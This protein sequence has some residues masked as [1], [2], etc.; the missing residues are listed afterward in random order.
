MNRAVGLSF[1]PIREGKTLLP[2]TSLSVMGEIAGVNMALLGGYLHSTKTRVPETQRPRVQPGEGWAPP[3][4][5]LPKTH[6]VMITYN[7]TI[8]D[9]LPPGSTRTATSAVHQDG[10]VKCATGASSRIHLEDSRKRQ[11][12][13]RHLEHKDT[14]TCRGTCRN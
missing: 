2:S 10:G 8:P 9:W 7:H 3:G 5:T 14:K 6:H 13:H 12:H 1:G 4:C 11:Q